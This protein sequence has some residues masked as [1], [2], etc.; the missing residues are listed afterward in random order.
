MM[1]DENERG[2]PYA[3]NTVMTRLLVMVNIQFQESTEWARGL[4]DK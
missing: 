1:E 3:E 4:G 2:L